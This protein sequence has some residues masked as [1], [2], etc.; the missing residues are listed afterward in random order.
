MILL[1]VNDVMMSA[2]PG[3]LDRLCFRLRE[4]FRF[5][6]F[7]SHEADFIHRL[8]KH[9]DN[10]VIIHKE[11]YIVEE[12]TPVPVARGRRGRHHLPLTWRSSCPSGPRRT[13]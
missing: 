9:E 5:G 3:S 8:I 13:R 12:L 7:E 6:K 4:R 10:R 1:D 11:K 2:R